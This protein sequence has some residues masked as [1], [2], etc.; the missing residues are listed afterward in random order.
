[1]AAGDIT[2]AAE[3]R[4]SS[5]QWDAQMALLVTVVNVSGG[6]ITNLLID[7]NITNSLLL[8]IGIPIVPSGQSWAPGAKPWGGSWTITTFGTSQSSTAVFFPTLDASFA[9]GSVD[10]VNEYGSGTPTATTPPPD[11]TVTYT[12][13]ALVSKDIVALVADTTIL[14]AGSRI[15]TKRNRAQEF[16]VLDP[17]EGHTW[18]EMA[19]RRISVAAA[20]TEAID[21]GGVGVGKYLLVES[22]IA[23]S[24]AINNTELAIDDVT[25]LFLIKG[26]FTG[27][28]IE[29]KSA[30]TAANVTLAVVD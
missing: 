14:S 11:V 5:G 9:E 19:L 30:T 6:V 22:D 17:V 10:A 16:Y 7:V 13:D 3:W 29:N 12:C 25:S 2:L 4:P 26:E 24:V 1:M 20:S 23:V 28:W 21:L 8:S 27:L 18:K 15:E